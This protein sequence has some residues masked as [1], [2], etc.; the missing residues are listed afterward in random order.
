MHNLLEIDRKK[1]LGPLLPLLKGE[2]F[3]LPGI[4]PED[5]NGVNENSR[6][7]LEGSKDIVWISLPG[8][9]FTQTP[10]YHDVFYL[11]YPV[12]KSLIY[13]HSLLN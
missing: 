5:K 10:V 2:V 9:T 4:F 13:C 6:S 3:L 12:Q 7:G 11:D 8:I 1:R